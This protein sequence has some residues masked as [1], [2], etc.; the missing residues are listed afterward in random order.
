M[1]AL[2]LSQDVD[3]SAQPSRLGPQ[4]CRPPSSCTVRFLDLISRF[5]LDTTKR[6]FWPAGGRAL[7]FEAYI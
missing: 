1:P 3:M 5:V 2:L 6:L 4:Q 7:A